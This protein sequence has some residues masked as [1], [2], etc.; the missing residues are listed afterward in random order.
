M[1][2]FSRTLYDGEYSRMPV[3][4]HSLSVGMRMQ[5]KLHLRNGTLGFAF[6][7]Q[8]FYQRKVPAK[9]TNRITKKRVFFFLEQGI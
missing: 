2:K 3:C 7:H 4:S 6:F 8:V 1:E 9:I 5:M